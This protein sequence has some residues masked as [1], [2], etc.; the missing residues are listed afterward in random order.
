MMRVATAA[1]AGLIALA[2]FLGASPA[3][4]ADGYGG[5]TVEVTISH[6]PVDEKEDFTLSAQVESSTGNPVD[7]DKLTYEFNG[8]QNTSGK[9]T[10]PKVSDDTK[11]PIAAYCSYDADTVTLGGGSAGKLATFVVVPS[12]V[13]KGSNTILVLDNDSSNNGDD[14]DDNNN[15]DDDDDNG[16]LPN[17]GGE[18]LAW[19]VIGLLLVAAG[20]TVVVSSRKRDAVA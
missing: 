20:S 18:R 5:A 12:A 15:K 4:A 11:F 1:M 13:A 2:G 6:P 8:K 9:F 7:C 19:L 14:D 10:S 3:N 17:T 16:N